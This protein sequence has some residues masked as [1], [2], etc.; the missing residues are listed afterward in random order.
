MTKP[1]LQQRLHLWL[2][3]SPYVASCKISESQTYDRM[4]MISETKA[5]ESCAKSKRKCG[6]ERPKCHRCSSRDLLCEYPP[7]RP[8]SFVLL[9]DDASATSHSCDMSI[10]AGHTT[11][12]WNP[13][14]LLGSL[15]DF[16]L[17]VF[18]GNTD[19][20]LTKPP[21]ASSKHLSC[22]WF[23]SPETWN[24]EE[25]MVHKSDSS[26]KPQPTPP[27]GNGVLRRFLKDIQRRLEAWVSTGGTTFIHKQLYTFQ[28]PRC[29]LDA[30]TA[31]ALYLSRTDVN[32]DMVFR[33]LDERAKQLL[34]E[35]AR[36]QT[37]S[38]HDAFSHLA[39]VQALLSYQI[40]GLLDG[41]IQQR[42]TAEGRMETLMTW[43]DQTIESVR[44]A[45]ASHEDGDHVVVAKGLGL[46][47]TDILTDD[48]TMLHHITQE[49][50]V[51]HIWIFA[52][53]LRRTW[54]IIQGLN[55]TYHALKKGWAMC[56]GS[57][58]VTAGQ[59]VWDAP[60]SHAW[61]RIVGDQNIWFIEG[62][63]T[64]V[65]FTQALPC[66][67]DEFTKSCM[68]ITYGM[69]RMERWGSDLTFPA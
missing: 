7:A 22:N 19:L 37:S 21:S 5:C 36:H 60:S 12:F 67:V 66:E 57:M 40:M 23:M 41:D 14:L 26:P 46:G 53:S 61:A 4:N 9:Q 54:I 69:E 62:T 30:Q 2:L 42:A 65:L 8:S 11:A 20:Q 24:S 58:K 16:D 1:A 25:T 48:Q 68:E 33:A 64:E 28:K 59:G 17:P 56:P 18:P 13:N 38:S 63:G 15:S 6:K 32:E 27:F 55:S 50:V 29:V 3:L 10:T 49:E 31:L 34:Q 45:S 43:L 47:I 44:T 51:W 52:E 35:E 39:R